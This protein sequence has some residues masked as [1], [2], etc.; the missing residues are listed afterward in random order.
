MTGLRRIGPAELRELGRAWHMEL[1]PEEA[2][3]LGLIAD[4]VLA[5]LDPLAAPSG[6]AA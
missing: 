2:E 3:Q 5:V 4:D 6:P 1:A